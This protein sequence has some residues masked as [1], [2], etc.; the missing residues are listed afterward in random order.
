MR[1]KIFEEYNN[2]LNKLKYEFEDNFKKKQINDLK[3]SDF[4]LI[5]TLG[6]GSF[7]SVVSI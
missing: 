2:Y 5:T 4:L 6:C 1:N 3:L 7:G